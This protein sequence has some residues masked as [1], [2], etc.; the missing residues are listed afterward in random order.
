MVR[1]PG[2]SSRPAISHEEGGPENLRIQEEGME[3]GMR[4]LIVSAGERLAT[5]GVVGMRPSA[6]L[7][8]FCPFCVLSFLS[9]PLFG[10]LGGR[11]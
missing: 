2:C 1:R 6:V 3:V 9:F 5:S 11:R 8:E 4:G 10:G 7:L